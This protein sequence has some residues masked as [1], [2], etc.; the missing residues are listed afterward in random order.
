MNTSLLYPLIFDA[1]REPLLLIDESGVIQLANSAAN[2]F[3]SVDATRT[4]SGLRCRDAH[5]ELDTSEL[6]GLIQAEEPVVGYRLPSVRGQ[7]G[8]VVVD[9]DSVPGGDANYWLLRVRPD[10]AGTGEDFW[11]DEMISL[12]SHEIKN[13]LSAMKHS[14][15]L[16]LSQA[17][18][19]LT[20]GQRRFL[21]TSGRS[22]DRL[23]HLVDGFLD[24]SR[25]RAGA[26]EVTRGPV[27]VH[28]FIND[29]M[30][31]FQ[32]LFN[33]TRTS[34]DWEV[35]TDTTDAHIDASKLEQV[36]LNLLS[37][38]LKFTPENGEIRVVVKSV[39][40]ETLD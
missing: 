36:L 26:F 16:L 5:S 11:K 12:V 7:R 31:S 9:L 4:V 21:N 39:G 18:G 13:P 20:D 30:R 37:N 33:V 28:N 38:A 27:D 14:V 34:I 10:A 6:V 17:P 3:F 32:T 2:D 19:E 1:I 23:V 29:A 15:D 25:I 40:V 24:V 22:I 35:D 8:S